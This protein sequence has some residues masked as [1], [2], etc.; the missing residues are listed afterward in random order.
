MKAAPVVT[1]AVPDRPKRVAQSGWACGSGFYFVAPSHTPRLT[2]IALKWAMP[3]PM[4]RAD[5]D[6]PALRL[7]TM[8]R[9]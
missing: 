4:G 3:S 7:V 9:T 2:A 1:T 6:R 8:V 5:P